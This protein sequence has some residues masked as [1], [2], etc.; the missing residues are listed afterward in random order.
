MGLE[1]INRSVKII[2][3]DVIRITKTYAE[4]NLSKTCLKYA[5]VKTST[6]YEWTFDAYAYIIIFE[7]PALFSYD[8]YK[9]Y[10]DL[11]FYCYDYLEDMKITGDNIISIYRKNF[12]K[13]LNS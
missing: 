8:F 1:N 4:K 9:L 11:R 10:S 6:Y 5:D 2:D 7:L 12:E 3:N 13:K